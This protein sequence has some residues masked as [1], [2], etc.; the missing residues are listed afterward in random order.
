MQ[1]RLSDRRTAEATVVGA[2]AMTDL[3][4]LKIDLDNLIAAEWGDSDKL[5]V[6]DLVWALGSPYGLERSLTFGIVSAKVAPQRQL[7]QPQPVS[8]ISCRPTRP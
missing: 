1:V 8:G 4:V 2:D 3:A 7:R 6:G 5:E